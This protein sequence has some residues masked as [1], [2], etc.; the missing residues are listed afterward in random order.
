MPRIE[1]LERFKKSFRSIGDEETTLAYRG[2][3]LEDLPLPENKIDE[4]LASLLEPTDSDDSV[5]TDAEETA[6]DTSE[7]AA[8]DGAPDDSPSGGFDFSDFLD[9]IPDSITEPAKE[10]PGETTPPA[11]EADF[12][13]PEDLLSGLAED[14]ESAPPDETPQAESG[15]S[16]DF[17]DIDFGDMADASAPTESDETAE[18]KESAEDISDFALPDLDAPSD[19]SEPA[20]MDFEIP[21][22]QTSGESETPAD[23]TALEEFGAEASP[24]AEEPAETGAPIEDLEGEAA[25]EAF[26]LFAE[27]SPVQPDDERESSEEMTD[28]SGFT[29]PEFDIEGASEVA[30]KAADDF[31]EDKAA[32]PIGDFDTPADA[33]DLVENAP[34]DSFDTFS[35]DDDFMAS[36]FGVQEEPGAQKKADD[37]FATLEDFSLEGID[38]VFRSPS[39]GAAAAPP[40]ADRRKRVIAPGADVEE[41]V[42]S[43]NDL[44]QLQETLAGYPLNLRIA[45]EELIAEHA[46]PPDQMAALIKMLVKG[47][48]AKD[49]ASIASRLIG[50]TI[51]IPRGFE[52]SSGAELEAEK[53]TFS[54]RFVHTILPILRI[55]V[56]AALVTASLAYLGMEF[57]YKPLRA[58]SLYA[59]G[60]K[61]IMEGDYA[62][63]N[64]RFDEAGRVWRIK[65]WY[66]TYARTFI[67]KRQYLFAEQKYDQLL[68]NYRQDKTAAL[69]YAAFETNVLRNYEKAERILRREILDRRLDDKEG[70]LA[71]GDNN[72]EWGE[73][74]PSRYE[75]ARKAY[76]RLM[77]KYGR[78]DEY[79]ERMLLYFIRTDNLAETLPLQEYFLASKKS[80]VSAAAL[81]ELGG[82][83]LDKKTMTFEGVPDRNIDKIENIKQL[84]EEAVKRDSKNPEAYYHL[85]RYYERYNR[86][87]E[88]KMAVTK[89]LSAFAAAPELSARRMSY[90]IE[91]H[92]K[93]ASLLLQEKEFISAE[94]MLVEGIRLFEDAKSR[95]LL[96]KAPQYG[97][98]YAELGDIEYFKAG[99]LEA[100]VRNYREAEANGYAPP[101]QRYRIGYAAYAREDWE[102]AVESFFKTSA[103]FQLNR[104][105]LFALGNALYRRGDLHA[106]QGYYKRL[107]DLLESERARFPVL[108]PNA[109]PDHA[110]LSERLM[111]A[112]NNLGV[113]LED[114]AERSGDS[115]Y[116]SR[117]LALYSE[118]ARA[119]DS[120][121]RDPKSMVRSE[122][123]NLA[124]LNTR[125]SLYPERR[126]EPQIYAE[127]DKDV[128]EPS[129]WEELLSE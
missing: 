92:R 63:G 45:C 118:S 121:T 97:K 21:D 101:E 2:E 49:T 77:G 36:G 9:S 52:K 78:K 120:L 87:R 111:R 66:F 30:P 104:R 53:S 79:L 86:P 40:A 70:L 117:A 34:I 124:F 8:P 108:V 103:E 7:G 95:R 98:L 80:K 4:D 24:S 109:R 65:K 96:E 82:Y 107:L 91:A 6:P 114:L 67:E 54:Y 115:R 69:E 76:A 32:P 51:S 35:L 13:I 58:N 102:G 90:R 14:V 42:L 73:L 37:G 38:D 44:T 23:E 55:F 106:A 56:F 12:G 39:Q 3:A 88:E 22:F 17:S 60:H 112:R 122:S 68:L 27:E 119:W 89:S 125:G 72:L 113:T 100:A 93:L 1:D 28:D 61:R 25:E 5:L 129:R 10:A 11:D 85:A 19:A 31:A 71:L 20:E 48:G 62:R 46:I 75:E 16:I 26:S 127:I 74:D 15:D 105:I 81:A 128:L 84:L 50:R 47:A 83:Y 41:I 43:E 64:E 116:R 110:D 18:E 33:E 99:D 126:F 94:E 57:V 123:A 59:Q 29:I